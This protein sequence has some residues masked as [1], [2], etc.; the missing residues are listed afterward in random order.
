MKNPGSAL[1]LIHN[2]KVFSFL[3]PGTRTNDQPANPTGNF[4]C[5]SDFS[6][7]Q[8]NANACFL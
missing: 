1:E 4:K 5:S 3:Y 7:K 8:M 2:L 6:Q